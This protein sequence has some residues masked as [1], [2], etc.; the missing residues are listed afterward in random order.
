[1]LCIC[2]PHVSHLIKTFYRT[3]IFFHDYKKIKNIFQCFRIDHH[4]KSVEITVAPQLKS[5]KEIRERLQKIIDNVSNQDAP[6]N[7]LYIICG[8]LFLLLFGQ[9]KK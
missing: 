7:G 9:A 3:Y 4:G 5:T 2:P 1:M 6:T 8:G